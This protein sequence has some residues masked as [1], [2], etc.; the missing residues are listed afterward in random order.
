MVRGVTNPVTMR[1]RLP[2]EWACGAAGSA[3]EWHSGGH[4]FDPGQVHHSYF[5]HFMRMA[6]LTVGFAVLAA[7]TAGCG[8]TQERHFADRERAAAT[9]EI[10]RGWIPDW[11]PSSARDIRERHHVDSGATL[12]SFAFDEK[13]RDQLVRQCEPA[14]TLPETPSR[15][16][17]A[18]VS[19]WPTE[20]RGPGRRATETSFRYF[21]C[22][23]QT[24]FAN[25]HVEQRNAA[26][27]VRMDAP[28]A[29][30]WR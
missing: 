9:G 24:K 22:R 10:S 14:G 16:L 19:W 20:L 17:V 25:G 13:D 11:L 2:D 30:F 27:A 6:R 3:P 15:A 7:L 29:F 23:E 12:L 21:R 5:V 18:G 4:R 1:V 8:E 26:L 28:V